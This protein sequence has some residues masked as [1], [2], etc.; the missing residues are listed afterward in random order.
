MLNRNLRNLRKIN[1]VHVDE[2]AKELG[3]STSH[4]YK[5]EQG[6]R[7]PSL[8]LAMKLS[9]YYDMDISKIF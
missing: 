3:I 1:K 8:D 4:Y 9:K 5:L 7:K 2:V 6:T